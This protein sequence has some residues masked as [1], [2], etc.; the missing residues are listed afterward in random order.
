[1]NTPLTR[2]TL[3]AGAGAGAVAA[4]LGVRPAW[5]D[6]PRPRDS[7]PP[8]ILLFTVDDMHGGSP[9]CYG[10]RA[11]LTPN[12]DRLAAE[13]V[14][15][16]RAH[17]PIAL[18]QPSRSALMTGRYPHRNGAE[19]FED[20]DAG[21]PILN[22]LLRPRGYLTGILGKVGH[23]GPS[24]RFAW[25]LSVPPQQLGMGRNPADYARRATELFE[26]ARSEDRPFFLMANSED[27]HRPFSGSDAEQDRFG[28]V[29][30]Q[31]AEPSKVYGPD[32]AE[33]PGF[34]PDLPDI[35]QEVSQYMSSARRAD[36]TLAAVLAALDGSGLAGDTI[37]IF[38]SDNGMAVPFGKANVYEQCTRTPLIVRWPGVTGAG[39]V[40][41]EHF[42][43]TMDLFPTLCLAAGATV[44]EGLDGRDLTSLLQGGSQSGRDRVTTVFHLSNSEQRYEMRG[45]HDERWSYVWN[46]WSDG[47]LSYRAENMMGLTWPAMR[48]STDPEVAA[49]AEFYLFRV[50]EELYDL[51]NDPD[52]L[53]NLADGGAP[54][55]LARG[56]AAM[57]AWM[58]ATGDP[59]H[60]RYREEIINA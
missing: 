49:R 42:V 33:V 16:H 24:D 51:A 52:A 47:S 38:M 1:M 54:E 22:E 13:G 28:D 18:C 10:G 57:D 29:L 60:D 26:R 41:D 34:L 4:G 21:V 37:V 50:R 46:A 5:S 17:V 7:R 55:A 11:D 27:P 32:D 25:D 15:F 20:I 19:G 45:V 9:G 23:L 58:G 36:D 3:L 30:D 56:R 43:S 39:R 35:R 8:N 48:D 44:P 14:A 2:R 59:L 6:T 12:I 40:D 31:I 53:H